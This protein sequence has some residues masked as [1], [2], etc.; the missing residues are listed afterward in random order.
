MSPMSKI[1]RSLGLFLVGIW[2][3]ILWHKVLEPVDQSIE[4]GIHATGQWAEKSKSDL[5]EMQRMFAQPLP[6]GS[7]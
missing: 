1:N 7:K 3:W 5:D 4:Q 2:L 6:G